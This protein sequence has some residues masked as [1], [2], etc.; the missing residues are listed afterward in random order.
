MPLV[1]VGHRHKVPARR[2]RRRCDAERGHE[3]EK[4]VHVLLRILRHSIGDPLIGRAVKGD[5]EHITGARGGVAI[6]GVHP[7]HR[8][9]LRRHLSLAPVAE[10][11][12][13]VT[14]GARAVLAEGAHLGE[15]SHPHG[16]GALVVAARTRH[17]LHCGHQSEAAAGRSVAPLLERA[18]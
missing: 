4:V 11:D 14:R 16:G 2:R 3:L 8:R 15:D 10:I 18:V 13:H 1:E 6:V 7:H 5:G 9:D 12:R 17:L